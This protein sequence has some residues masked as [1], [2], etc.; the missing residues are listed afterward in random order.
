LDLT[1]FFVTKDG[2]ATWTCVITATN[3]EEWGIHGFD[4]DNARICSIGSA[5]HTDSDVYHIIDGYDESRVSVSWGGLYAITF[6]SSTDGWTAGADLY[7]TTNGGTSWSKLTKP[8]GTT[9][10]YGVTAVSTTTAWACGENGTIIKTTDATNWSALTSGVSV[11]LRDIDFV[12][13]NNGWCVGDGG[14][15][16]VTTNGGSTWIPEDSGTTAALRAVSTV[17]ATHAWV[18]GFGG[19]ILRSK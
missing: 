1:P 19:L 6:A 12:D 11:V 18:C 17:D 9:Q 10:L 2:G 4:G 15:I 16:L 7:H 14:T 13:A 8:P 3:F 5:S